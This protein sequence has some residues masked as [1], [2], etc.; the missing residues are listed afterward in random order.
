MA[1]VL[2]PGVHHNCLHDTQILGLCQYL[3]FSLATFF[4]S[5]VLSRCGS[6]PAARGIFRPAITPQSL[7]IIGL[8]LLLTPLSESDTTYPGKVL[9]AFSAAT[10]LPLCNH[11]LPTSSLSLLL[12][13]QFY[14]LRLSMKFKLSRLFALTHDIDRA[15]GQS[16][17]KKC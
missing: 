15:S 13:G 3:L 17:C 12:I 9:L 5:L 8:L 6:L 4:S 7:A 1:G 14:F 10:L 2:T 11:A 16:L